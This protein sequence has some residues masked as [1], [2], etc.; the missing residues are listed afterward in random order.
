VLSINFRNT[1]ALCSILLLLSCE[2]ENPGEPKANEPP[3]TYI[4]E[5]SAGSIT[6]ISFYGTDTDGFVDNFQ[7]Q[8]AG[9]IDW[10]VTS[11]RTVSFTNLFS[12]ETDVKVFYVKGIDNQGLEDPTPAELSLTPSNTLPETEIT[13]GPEFGSI[14]GEDVIFTFKGADKEEGGSIV[15]FEYTMDNLDNWLE[16][17]LDFAQVSFSGLTNGPHVFYVRAV[18]INDYN[19][20]IK[21]G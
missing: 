13:S 6:T 14:T 8:W 5:A 17:P 4:S 12:S 11:R 20:I 3:D 18:S 10:T 16:R 2:T 15:K 19:S 9:E 21:A 7:Y 1:L